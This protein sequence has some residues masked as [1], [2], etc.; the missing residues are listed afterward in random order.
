MNHTHILELNRSELADLLLDHRRDVPPFEP[1]P[2]SPWV[3]MSLMQKSIRRGHVD[4]ALK[5]AA[6]LLHISPDR[7]WRRLGITA[8]EDIGVADV[9][10]V[11]LVMAGMT[12]KIWRRGV[13]GEWVVAS[14][15]IQ[16]MC[17]SVKCR[18][19][20]DLVMVCTG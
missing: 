8:V 11:S 5:G 4:W 17:Q 19:A 3:A 12:G 6:T 13:G 14:Y 10:T 16:R 1:L 15:L 2:I 9:D 20:D 18:A 7:L